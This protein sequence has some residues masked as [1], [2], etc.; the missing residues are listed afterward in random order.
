MCNFNLLCCACA[1]QQAA[2][3]PGDLQLKAARIVLGQATLFLYHSDLVL[4]SICDPYPFSMSST[5]CGRATDQQPLPPGASLGLRLARLLIWLAV[6]WP[7]LLLQ[8]KLPAR[9]D[10]LSACSTPRSSQSRRSCLRGVRC[11][12]DTR[13][14]AMLL[15]EGRAQHVHHA[16]CCRCQA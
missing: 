10:I 15:S 2:S 13:C 16:L 9:Q 6:L 11:C 14:T 12:A 4:F 7:S 5:A 8:L 1:T 3:Y